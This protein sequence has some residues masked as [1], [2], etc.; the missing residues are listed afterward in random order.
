MV[1]DTGRL[2]PHYDPTPHVGTGRN[3][4]RPEVRAVVVLTPFHRYGT[5]PQ[6]LEFN[7]SCG[8]PKDAHVGSTLRLSPGTGGTGSGLYPDESPNH[9]IGYES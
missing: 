6:T 3:C 4:R 2:D 1:G 8:P 9:K 5:R 7:S